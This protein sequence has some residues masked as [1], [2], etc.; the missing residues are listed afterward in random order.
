DHSAADQRAPDADDVRSVCAAGRPSA[1]GRRGICPVGLYVDGTKKT[2]RTSAKSNLNL[3]SS[4]PRSRARSR[5][6]YRRSAD[7]NDVHAEAARNEAL[8]RI[9]V[10]STYTVIRRP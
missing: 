5:G 7:T 10:L 2:G 8:R 1:A 4:L 9:D 3:L 6:R